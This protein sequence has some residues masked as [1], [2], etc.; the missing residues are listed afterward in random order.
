MKKYMKE[1][2]GTK[3]GKIILAVFFLLLISLSVAGALYVFNGSEWTS[4]GQAD[5]QTVSG[6]N[7]STYV[8]TLSEKSISM[9]TGDNHLLK[10]NAKDTQASNAINWKS[11]NNKIVHVDPLGNLTALKK[12]T[13]TITATAG[14]YSSSCVVKVKEKKTSDKK[15]F[16]TCY[17]AN[18]VTLDKNKKNNSGQNLY[19]IEINRLK[20][21]VTIYTYDEEGNYT[22]PVR[23]MICSC[24]DGDATPK[25]EFTIGV[26]NRWHTLFG[27]VYGQYTTQF[28]GDILFH[29]V[30]Y[31]VMNDPSSVEVEEYN[32]LGK[33][34][35]MGCVRL[36][37]A[38]TKWIYDNC[39]IG[40][41]VKV[42][43]DKKD[44]PLGTPPAMK[45]NTG[46]KTGWDPTDDD[47]NNPYYKKK[48]TFDGVVN[49]TVDKGDYLD[50]MSGVSAKDT[51]G[52]NITD[53]IKVKGKA[54]TNKSGEYIVNYSVTD[55]MGRSISQYR[56]ITVK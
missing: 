26:K 30:P 36:A 53:R 56:Y 23:A 44:G 54:D 37:L 9:K 17:T 5:V 6:K 12:G 2:L 10:I 39:D 21:C 3:G 11:D 38:D 43:E 29:S 49:I 41:A 15:T 27:N 45:I 16:S 40:T 24:G 20:N 31:E 46:K 35:S 7:Y 48:P 42:Y 19:S 33:S 1:S 47:K 8:F 14:Y 22:V 4:K 55:D 32:N 18:K 28:N 52:S 50:L 34:V 13:A 51:S 25:G